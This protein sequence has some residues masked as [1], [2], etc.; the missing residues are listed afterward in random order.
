MLKGLSKKISHL[1]ESIKKSLK[2][3]ERIE[4][5]VRHCIF[6]SVSHKKKRHPFFSREGC[7]QNLLQTTENE[8]IGLTFFLDVFHG[9]PDDHF[10]MKQ[11]K[12]PVVLLKEGTEAGTF[13]RM[14]EHIES[15]KLAS[16]TIVYL[17]E[18]DYLHRE[19]WPM[20]LREGFALKK[21]EYVT[22]YD[23]KDKYF[24]P[25]YEYLASYLYLSPSTHWRTTPSTTNTYAMRYRT[26]LRDIAIH[27]S[28][29]TER[30]ISA[31]HEKFIQLGKNG[32][33]L[34]S[35]IPGW[36]THM[37]PS[38]ESPCVDWQKVL[39]QTTF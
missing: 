25:D 11:Q 24:A 9:S 16:E 36:S 29:S 27:K 39:S 10:L 6:S 5:F 33:V 15:R 35:P 32:A 21:A 34:I 18:D 31:D 22:L 1:K 4:V 14:L 38:Y 2:K 17:L 8:K 3:E 7:Y 23:H 30:S 12:Y 19:G 13:L 28:F 26:L 20:I 37:E